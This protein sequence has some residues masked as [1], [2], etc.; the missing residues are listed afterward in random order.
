MDMKQQVFYVERM[1]HVEEIHAG[2][3]VVHSRQPFL[4]SMLLPC[5]V[6]STKTNL[7]RKS[8]MFG[9]TAAVQVINTLESSS[10]S[11]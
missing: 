4:C 6:V 5:M 2:Q 3:H 10:H 1:L 9:D 7:L 8:S 11:N